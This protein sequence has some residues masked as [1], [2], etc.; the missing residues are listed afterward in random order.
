VI[1]LSAADLRDLEAVVRRIQKEL[2]R[3]PAAG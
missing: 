1:R 3:I 2:S